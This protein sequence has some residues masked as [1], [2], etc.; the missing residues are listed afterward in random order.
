MLEID[1]EFVTPAQAYAA[2]RETVPNDDYLRPVLEALKKPL[3]NLVKCF[4]FG[5]G[6]DSTLYE[7]DA[8][9]HQAVGNS[10]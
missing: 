4:G 5:A 7:N 9:N 8:T 10:C 3:G 6:M 2:V 1:E